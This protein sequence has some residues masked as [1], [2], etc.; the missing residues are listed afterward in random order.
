MVNTLSLLHCD[1]IRMMLSTKSKGYSKV[2]LLAA[3]ELSSV[4]IDTLLNA[5][6][7]VPGLESSSAER[8]RRSSTL[9]D[10]FK[11]LKELLRPM[12]SEEEDLVEHEEDG[13]VRGGPFL[14]LPFA[15]F[16]G[17][18]A[19]R[20]S[21]ERPFAESSC[22]GDGR[23]EV[24]GTADDALFGVL[25]DELDRPW[26]GELTS[27][28]TLGDGNGMA[29][30]ELRSGSDRVSASSLASSASCCDSCPFIEFCTAELATKCRV[31]TVSCSGN[32]CLRSCDDDPVAYEEAEELDFKG[33]L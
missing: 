23:A 24:R 27:D 14:S 20:C 19:A 22:S 4:G 30:R 26:G 2:W 12:A 15:L 31:S 9:G 32:N 21:L 10:T 5:A 18:E 13:A 6:M 29:R 28:G 7:G 11:S 16:S 8:E 17:S 1:K 3:L 33:V 25:G